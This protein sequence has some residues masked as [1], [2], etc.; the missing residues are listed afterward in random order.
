MVPHSLKKRKK[1]KPSIFFITNQV[2]DK[3]EEREIWLV[4]VGEDPRDQRE[5]KS[6]PEDPKSGG[7]GVGG[8]GL[9]GRTNRWRKDKERIRRWECSCVYQY[10]SLLCG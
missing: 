10:R 7:V 6:G 5:A 4:G 2:E 1:G 9:F 3:I 8:C